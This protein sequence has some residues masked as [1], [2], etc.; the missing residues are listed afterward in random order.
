[1]NAR[2][3]QDQFSVSRETMKKIV[4]YEALLRKW[5]AKINL[6]GPATLDAFWSRHA[7]D[8]LQLL[9]LAGNKPGNWLDLG[10]GA[11]FPGLILALAGPQTT[12]CYLVESDSRKAAFLSAVIRETKAPATVLNQR[13]EA[14]NGDALPKIDFITARALAPLPKLLSLSAR[15]F[16]SSTIALFPKGENWQQELTQARQY[17]TV[18]YELH[19]SATYADARIIAITQLLPRA[20]ENV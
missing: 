5:Q 10:S 2:L 8:S 20:L 6:V 17:W 4:I 9:K 3:F 13:I 14:V 16:D 12:H 1:M 15:F 7:A 19:E 18:S 11:G